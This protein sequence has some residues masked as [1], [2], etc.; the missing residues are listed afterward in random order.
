MNHTTGDNTEEMSEEGEGEDGDDRSGGGGWRD[1]EDGS[2]EGGSDRYIPSEADDGEEDGRDGGDNMEVDR[3]NGGDIDE[4]VDEEEGGN[5]GI[6]KKRAPRHSKKATKTAPKASDYAPEVESLLNHA[7]GFMRALVVVENPMPSV[8][9]S[10]T[11]A[12]DAF[13]TAK[14][15]RPHV[16]FPDDIAHISIVSVSLFM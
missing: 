8:D 2:D 14:F 15:D 12:T 6:R 11:L 10:I 13:E 3:R 9:D 5:I 1:D 16:N 4:D 7:A